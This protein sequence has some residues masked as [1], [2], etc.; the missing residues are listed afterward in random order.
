MWASC[1]ATDPHA[2]GDGAT[3]VEDEQVQ[4]RPID[5]RGKGRCVRAVRE[6]RVVRVQLSVKLSNLF[7]VL[8]PSLTE[9]KHASG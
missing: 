5:D 1:S 8:N 9:D 6:L 2:S 4:S 7:E 3:G